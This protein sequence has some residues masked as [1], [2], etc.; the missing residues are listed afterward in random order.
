MSDTEQ[1][2][3]VIGVAEAEQLLFDA[4]QRLL[5]AMR[6]GAELV[7]R[8]TGRLEA[9]NA[10]AARREATLDRAYERLTQLVQ[11]EEAQA[12][13][14]VRPWSLAAA[15]FGVVGGLLGWTLAAVTAALW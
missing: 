10:A 15:L 14:I 13:W 12:Q 2:G 1:S 8:T 4:Q 9:A 7:E 5:A 3:E 6:R 11:H